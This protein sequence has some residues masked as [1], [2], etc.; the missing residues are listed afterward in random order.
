MHDRNGTELKVGDR[1][2]LEGIITTLYGGETYCN[3]SIQGTSYV[4][5]DE[6]RFDIHTINTHE[7]Y[8][9]NR[10]KVAP[11]TE[12]ADNSAESSDL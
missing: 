5:P 1:V 7:L 10:N 9:V 12:N 11:S 4:S 6:G 2:A 3:V 8:L